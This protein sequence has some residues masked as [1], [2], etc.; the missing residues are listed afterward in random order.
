M[1]QSIII[2]A[3][4]LCSVMDKAQLSSFVESMKQRELIA[5]LMDALKSDVPLVYA[6]MI[7]ER[8]RCSTPY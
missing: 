4:C 7:G 6:A 8:D 5:T 3:S 2:H 1:Q